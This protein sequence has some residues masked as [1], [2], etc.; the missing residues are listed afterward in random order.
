MKIVERKFT[1]FFS[2]RVDAVVV[3]KVVAVV[4]VAAVDV[5]QDGQVVVIVA[6][7]TQFRSAGKQMIELKITPVALHDRRLSRP[8]VSPPVDLKVDQVRD[9]PHAVVKMVKNDIDRSIHIEKA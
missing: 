5:V 6:P 2:Y 4:A 9:G 1:N 8:K 3:V 7:R